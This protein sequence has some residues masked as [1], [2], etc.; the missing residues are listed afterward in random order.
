MLKVNFIGES[1]IDC[2]GPRREFFRLLALKSSEGFFQG[3]SGC[4]VFVNNVV[5]LQVCRLDCMFAFVH[6]HSVV[7]RLLPSWSVCCNVCC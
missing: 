6:T 7:K 4:K 3:R 2:G 5:A 1:A